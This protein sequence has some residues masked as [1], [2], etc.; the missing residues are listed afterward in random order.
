MAIGPVTGYAIRSG[1]HVKLRLGDSAQLY[2]PRM[3]SGVRVRFV[4]VKYKI[5]PKIK[6]KLYIGLDHRFSL[7][8][9]AQ[10]LRAV[11]S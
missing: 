10:D 2:S 3:I 8:G 6:Q 9:N 1:S 4:T 7:G 11:G 5:I